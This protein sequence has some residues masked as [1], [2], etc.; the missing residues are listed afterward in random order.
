MRTTGA[1]EKQ[2]TAF[3][4][5]YFSQYRKK[6][7]TISVELV[8]NC[9]YCNL[10]HKNVYFQVIHFINGLEAAGNMNHEKSYWNFFENYMGAAA[11]L[12]Y[13]NHMEYWMF[14]FPDA[15]ENNCEFAKSLLENAEKELEKEKET[16]QPDYIKDDFCEIIRF[17]V[18]NLELIQ[19]KKSISRKEMTFK[20]SEP[21]S[22]WI[23]QNEVDRLKELKEKHADDFGVQL[24][25]SYREGKIYL[26]ELQDVLRE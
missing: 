19:C 3:L 22:S 10:R 8:D 24:E 7:K 25:K 9:N 23:H 14:Q 13:L 15:A 11:M 26:P 5:F 16:R 21:K 4:R 20:F 17:I 1:G 12:G 2:W 6:N 18:K